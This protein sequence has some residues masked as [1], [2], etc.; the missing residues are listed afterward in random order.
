MN[1]AE[2]IRHLADS[3]EV[4]QKQAEAVLSTL[5]TT[6]HIALSSGGEMSIPELG[7]FSMKDRAARTARNP[8]T[9]ETVEVAAKRVP[10]FTPSKVL[11]DATA[12]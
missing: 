1:K 11:K 7:K 6:V 5:A 9:G 10:K 4:T 2:L 8:A 3:A 12:G